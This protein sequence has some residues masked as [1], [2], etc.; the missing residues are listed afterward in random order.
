MRIKVTTKFDCTTTGVTGNF[1]PAQLPLVT[2]TGLK[3]TT[4]D[5]WNHARNQQRNWETITQLIGLYAQLE[6]ITDCVARQDTWEF[7]FETEFQGVFQRGNDELGA[8][9][10]SCADVP[11]VVG[12]NEKSLQ[13]SCLVPDQ[14]IWFEQLR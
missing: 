12:L 9:K 2:A 3:I 1:R 11:M 14:N 10:N 8:L 6:N 5:E 7:E 13:D 4:Y